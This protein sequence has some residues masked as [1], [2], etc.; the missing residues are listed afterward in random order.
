[1][2]W[3][4]LADGKQELKLADV[5]RDRD[6][7]SATFAA[8]VKGNLVDDEH[9]ALMQPDGRFTILSLADGHTVLEE[10]LAAE[11]KLEAIFVQRSADQDI[12][13]VDRAADEKPSAA[14]RRRHI[15]PPLDGSPLVTGRI[16]AFN[17]AINK[18]QWSNPASVEE[19]GLLL[20]QPSE[21]PVLMFMRNIVDPE[22]GTP[23][24]RGSVLC[25]DKQT[26]RLVY[27][28]DNLP[29]QLMNLDVVANAD[30]KSV[31]MNFPQQSVVLKFTEQP[32]APEP[33]YQAPPF[34]S[35]EWTVRDTLG[36]AI[37]MA[38]EPDPEPVKV[39]QDPFA[40]H[41]PRK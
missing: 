22:S 24:Q 36:R 15:Q 5:W 27:E 26:G 38:T 2:S 29:Q 30:D 1:L 31:S 35:P 11:P 9:V 17:R 23:N 33:P 4:A 3:K 7:W 8:G 37:K 20:S 14:R 40:P 25:I 12:L 28:D 16:Y 34:T 32:A 10:K 19:H 18:L 6:V 13:V 41:E 39:N 21:L